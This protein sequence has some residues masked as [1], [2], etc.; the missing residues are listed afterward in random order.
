M[1]D[2]Y[3]PKIIEIALNRMQVCGHRLGQVKLRVFLQGNPIRT[4][5]KMALQ[6]IV[7]PENL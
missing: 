3:A 1:G 5:T 7:K 2:K 6:G 4:K